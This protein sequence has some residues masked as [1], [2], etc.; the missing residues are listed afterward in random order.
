MARVR[1]EEARASGLGCQARNVWLR[2][3]NRWVTNANN[4]GYVNS[5]GNVN[6]TNANNSGVCAAP[7]WD[8]RERT[9]ELHGESPRR[10]SPRR[11]PKSRLPQGREPG[12][13][14]GAGP[15]THA[16]I[17][18]D[19]RLE[20]ATSAEGLY[21][22][23]LRCRRGVMWKTSVSAFVLDGWERCMRLSDELRSSDYHPG[24]PRK[25]EVTRPKRREITACS[26]RDRVWQQSLV[27]NV[28][29]PA[30]TRGLIRE[31]C[32][33]Q[34]GKGTDD[35]RNLLARDLRRWYLAHG[36]DGW[37]LGLDVAGYYAH[38]R[39]EDIEALFR[40]K[41]SPAATAACM[42]IVEADYSGEV[43]VTAG[44]PLMQVVGISMLSPIDH[45]VK[46]RLR[47]RNYVRYM[48]DM[49]MVGGREDLERAKSRIAEMLGGLGMELNSR[50]TRLQ[51][52]S[53]PIPWLGVVFRLTDTGKVV[54]TIRPEKVREERRRLRRLAGLA[55]R[56]EIPRDVADH[57]AASWIGYARRQCTSGS[58]ARGMERFYQRLYE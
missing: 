17:G 30:L 39:H 45:E 6:N 31:N 8:E 32:A 25:F 52:A 1:E 57:A 20:Y 48:D 10:K 11:E 55:Q 53:Q 23:M 7:D 54:R 43:G 56:G 9:K 28:V 41:L 24:R 47:I 22:A 15:R 4:V 27:D 29:T 13:G 26:F 38:M 37:T 44:S 40:S 19:E 50:K 34:V 36:T 18:A 12:I 51:P 2:S 49:L 3:A 58:T 33:C 46:E 21:Q 35:A 16:P 14:D 42:Q 5:D